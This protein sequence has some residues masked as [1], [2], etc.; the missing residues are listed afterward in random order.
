[1][2][3][4]KRRAGFTLIELLVIVFIVVLVIGMIV[5][6]GRQKG[7]AGRIKCVN[8]LKN[9]GLAFRIFATDNNDRFPG[10]ILATNGVDLASINIQKL[11]GALSNELSTPKILYCPED[12]QRKPA[13]SFQDFTSENVSY[14]GSLSPDESRPQSLLAG[15]RNILADGK[16][17]SRLL[18]LSTNVVLSWSK[19]I[20]NQQGNVALGD[21]SVHQMSSSEL[22][23]SVRNGVNDATNYLVFPQ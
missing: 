20:H 4:D 12:K 7:K 18:P 19:D 5:P 9:V 15:D 3:T 23:Q 14:F 11:F 8:N 21:G 2:I 13:E 16:L 1:M 17:A 22:Q 10:A 6:A